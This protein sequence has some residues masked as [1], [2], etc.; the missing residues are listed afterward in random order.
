MAK[1]FIDNYYVIMQ[2]QYTNLP[3]KKEKQKNKNIIYF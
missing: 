1:A 3:A 2:R